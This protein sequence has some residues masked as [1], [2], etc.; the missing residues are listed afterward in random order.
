MGRFSSEYYSISYL[1]RETATEVFIFTR[2]NWMKVLVDKIPAAALLFG[3]HI[4]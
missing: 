3:D 4:V 2:V 1:L